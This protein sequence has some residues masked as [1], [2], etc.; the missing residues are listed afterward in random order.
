MI[1]YAALAATE[2][3]MEMVTLDFP[4]IRMGLGNV[5]VGDATYEGLPALWFGVGGRGLD[6]P[7]QQLNRLAHDGE[8]LALFTFAD[9]RGLEAIEHACARLRACMTHNT[10]NNPPEGSG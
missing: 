6:A 4:I 3:E 2:R 10:G 7:V 8:T 9:I 1:G 5:E